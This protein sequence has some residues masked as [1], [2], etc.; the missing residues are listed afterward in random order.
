MPAESP[1]LKLHDISR[2]AGPKK[3]RRRVGRGHG[4]GRGKTSG[5]GQDGQMSRSGSRKRYRFEGGQTPIMMR[6][7]KLGGFSNFKFKKTYEPI[8]VGALNVFED[9]ATITAAELLSLGLIHGPQYKI[10]GDG[11]LTKSLTV[12]A[13]SFSQSAASKIEAVGGSAVTESDQTT[14]APDSGEQL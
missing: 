12:H 1:N 6:S 3:K 5:R 14:V 10:L 13:P 9:G 7:P 8:N 4:S 11:E 2:L